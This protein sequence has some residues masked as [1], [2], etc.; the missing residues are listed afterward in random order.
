M[1]IDVCA[2]TSRIHQH[3][4][5]ITKCTFDAKTNVETHCYHMGN[6]RQAS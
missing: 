4:A 6:V 5:A 1:A 2:L 3:T